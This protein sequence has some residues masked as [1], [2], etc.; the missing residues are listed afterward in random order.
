M[1]FVG[2]N[3]FDRSGRDAGMWLNE[4]SPTRI[5]SVKFI[6]LY[7]TMQITIDVRLSETIELG[8]YNI[9]G[10]RITYTVFS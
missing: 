1:S 10:K 9:G 3:L 4:F 6:R 2:S 5:C 8:T 7:G